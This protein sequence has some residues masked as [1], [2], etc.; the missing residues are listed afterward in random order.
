MGRERT[1]PRS[2]LANGTAVTRVALEVAN[3]VD[4][5]TGQQPG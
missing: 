2:G 5:V 1:A 3:E 4:M